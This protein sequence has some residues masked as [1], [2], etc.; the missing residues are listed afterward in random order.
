MDYGR[1][2]AQFEAR[3]AI[4]L[5]PDYLRKKVSVR[6]RV[7][8]VDTSD[9]EHC[10][11]K[12]NHG[13]T[14]HFGTFKAAAEACKVG[15]VVHLDGIVKAADRSRITLDPAFGRDPQAP[16]APVRP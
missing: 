1:P 10:V 12:L 15:E 2:A 8:A 16:L 9:P 4:T 11:V 6:G 7:S 13:V 14:A 3:D 5:A